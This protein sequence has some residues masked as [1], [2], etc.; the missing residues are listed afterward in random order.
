MNL[1]PSSLESPAQ[2]IAATLPPPSPSCPVIIRNRCVSPR[3]DTIVNTIE[4][5][6]SPSLDTTNTEE[7]TYTRYH[8]A[9]IIKDHSATPPPT[10]DIVS[11]PLDIRS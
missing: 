4:S 10:A 5:S 9:D 7:Y 1:Y 2:S 6:S 11:R 8:A 3:S